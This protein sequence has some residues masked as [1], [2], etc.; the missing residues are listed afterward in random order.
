MEISDRRRIILKKKFWHLLQ[1][2]ELCIVYFMNFFRIIKKKVW[3]V[4]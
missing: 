1:I 4:F 3:G 2:I